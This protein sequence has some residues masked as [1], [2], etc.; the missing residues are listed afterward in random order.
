MRFN[1]KLIDTVFCCI[2]FIMATSQSL[3]YNPA[4]FKKLKATKECPRCDLR[5]ADLSGLDL[6]LADFYRKEGK[7]V[8]MGG[9]HATICPEEAKQH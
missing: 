2:L 6:S 8:I 4:D 3:A 5:D 1:F 7:C 9:I